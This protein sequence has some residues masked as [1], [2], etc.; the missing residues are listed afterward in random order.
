MDRVDE[1]DAMGLGR[2]DQALGADPV[3]EE[4]HG[5]QA[6]ARQAEVLSQRGPEIDVVVV[7][8]GDGVDAV[9]AHEVGDAADD[10]GLVVEAVLMTT[11]ASTVQQF[12]AVAVGVAAVTAAVVAVL[13]V[14]AAGPAVRRKS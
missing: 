1:A 11:V 3:A 10:L 9:R 7:Q 8:G 6:E 12:V 5:S 2:H 4:P 13:A 14:R